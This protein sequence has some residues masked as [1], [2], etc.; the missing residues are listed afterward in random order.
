MIDKGNKRVSIR[1]Q[2]RLFN[3]S[4]SGTYYKKKTIPAATLSLMKRIDAIYMQYPFFGSRQ[5]TKYLRNEGVMISRKKVVRLMRIMGLR[6]IY[7]EPRTT[8]PSQGHRK[9]P[10]LLSGVSITKSNQVWSTD[11]TYIPMKKGFMY[12]CAV[13]GWAS[14]KILSWR[15]SNSMETGF[16]LEALKE[17]LE[18]YGSPEIFNT[19]Q[20]SQFTSAAFTGLLESYG[21]KISMDSKRRWVDNVFIERL[22]RSLKYENIYLN[23]YESGTDLREGLREWFDFYNTKRPHTHGNGLTPDLMYKAA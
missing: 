23:E 4:R 15:V 1:V 11:I 9:Y 12:L 10:Y 21:I 13:M 19:D 18:K 14:R 7:Q 6:A 5:I 20:G 3:I 17:A 8:I 22:W 2:C 16:C